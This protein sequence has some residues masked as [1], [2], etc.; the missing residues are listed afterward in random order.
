MTISAGDPQGDR[1]TQ[2]EVL[3]NAYGRELER[4]RLDAGARGL[5]GVEYCAY[6]V[7]HIL[8]ITQWTRLFTDESSDSD[9][10]EDD[11][12][13]FHYPSSNLSARRASMESGDYFSRPYSTSPSRRANTVP[14]NDQS[15]SQAP[16]FRVPTRDAP[17]EVQTPRWRPPGPHELGSEAKWEKDEDVGECR[18]CRRKFTFLFRKVIFPSGIETKQPR[19]LILSYL[20]RKYS[21]A[22]A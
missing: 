7:F 6:I 14:T 10:D 5:L 11:S 19:C 9:E 12:S 4:Q 17:Q 22:A 15:L 16:E 1:K 13:S 21:R 3:L 8:P 20:A 18:G 2:A